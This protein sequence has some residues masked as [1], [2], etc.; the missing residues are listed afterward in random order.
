MSYVYGRRYNNHYGKNNNFSSK[1]GNII[2]GTTLNSFQPR[3][4]YNNNQNLYYSTKK[5]SPTRKTPYNRPAFNYGNLSTTTKYKSVNKNGIDPLISNSYNIINNFNSKKMPQSNKT[6]YNKRLNINN[7]NIN[8]LLDYENKK[9]EK[10]QFY[11]SNKN[12]NYNNDYK[13]NENNN[14]SNNNYFTNTHYQYSSQNNAMKNIKPTSAPN[15]ALMNNNNIN[16]V[17][18]SLESDTKKN[19]KI[20]NNQN[21]AKNNDN[22]N[23]FCKNQEKSSDINLK[24]YYVDKCS[25]VLNYAYKEDSNSHYRDYMEDKGRAIENLN[26][27]ENN[28]LFCLFDGHGGSEVSTYLQNNFGK[29]MKESFPFTPNDK[30]LFFTDLFKKIDKKL[31]ELNYFEIGSTAVII[32]ITK[33]RNNNKKT[34][35]CANIGDSRALLI[36]SNEWK[37]LSYDDRTSDQ[38]EHD[39][40]IKEGGIVIDGRVNGQL[41]LSR[42][43]G[44]WELKNY[45]VSSEPHVT[46]TEINSDD[47]F[48]VMASDGVWDVMEDSEIYKMSLLATNSKDLCNNIMNNTIE[49]RSMDNISCFVIHLN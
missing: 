43:F 4:T 9:K 17:I 36:K 33:E 38:K 15:N 34:L 37:R 46:K 11:F 32:Y 20:I 45:G 26:N 3:A 2:I 19:D 18:K 44:D 48:V 6:I 7:D 14:N 23:D 42:A 40:I 1:A 29:H 47:L 16:T 5:I 13:Q 30:L 41:M 24:E 21:N 49:K 39:R 22:I 35:Y 27:D 8:N 28:A 31:K 12:N 10:E 25:L